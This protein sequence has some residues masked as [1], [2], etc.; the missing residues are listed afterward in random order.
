MSNETAVVQPPVAVAGLNQLERVGDT[1][2]VPAKTFKDILRSSSCWLPIVLLIV[3]T[4]ASAFVVDKK[5]GFEQ[6][7]E[8]QMHTPKA[9]ERMASLTPEQRAQSA[10]RTIPIIKFSTYGFSVFLL[11]ISAIYALVLWASFN[12]GL[13]AQTTFPQVFAVT[14]YSAL[15]YLVTVLLIILTVAFG[16]DPE[17]YNPQNPVGTNLAYYLPDVTGPLKGLLQSLDIVKIWSDVLQV[18]GMAIIAKKTITQAA[19][20]VGIF[21]LIGV[22]FTVMGAMFS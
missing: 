11:I 5:V 13:G 8:N 9:E 18:I 14:M 12:F 22:V 17:A 19:I 10:Q 7:Y 20:I 2:V 4:L 16:G 1:F 21:W 3:S 6:V 15:P